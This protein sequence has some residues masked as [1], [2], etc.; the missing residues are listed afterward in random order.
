MLYLYLLVVDLF[1]TK[2]TGQ[3]W[4]TT[5]TLD[6]KSMGRWAPWAALDLLFRWAIFVIGDW[7]KRQVFVT[8]KTNCHIKYDLYALFRD[9]ISSIFK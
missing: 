5:G 4:S 6:L 3:D 8:T 2:Q 7:K 1:G 9:S